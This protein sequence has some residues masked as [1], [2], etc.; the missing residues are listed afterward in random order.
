MHGDRFIEGNKTVTIEFLGKPARFPMSPVNLAARF[1]VPVSFVFAMK[2]SNTNYH[3]YATPLLY[4]QFSRNLHKR[5]QH[6]TQ[7]VKGYVEALERA[8]KKYPLQWFNYY[9]FWMIPE[10]TVL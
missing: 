2:E 6:L 5:E 1:N 3:F 7:A 9:N 4:C 8:V 10:K